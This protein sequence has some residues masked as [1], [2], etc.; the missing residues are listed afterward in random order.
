LASFLFGVETRDPLV[1]CA[2][3]VF[4]SAV[5]FVAVWLPAQGAIGSSP[6]SA[7]RSE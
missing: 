2:V 1:F 5:A 4:L 6:V 3:P 7:L